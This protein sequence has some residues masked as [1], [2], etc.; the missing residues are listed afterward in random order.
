[1]AVLVNSRPKLLNFGRPAARFPPGEKI[2]SATLTL[3]R[4]HQFKFLRKLS[5]VLKFFFASYPMLIAAVRALE[6]TDMLLQDAS[7]ER[8]RRCEN[9]SSGLF[10]SRITNFVYR[11][12]WV[13][14]QMEPISSYVE[15]R[16][17]EHM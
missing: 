8:V 3:L 6:A 13:T 7:R 2:G 12:D 9:L 11:C 10:S 16:Y 5:L 17:V 14:D 4:G 1:M 15:S